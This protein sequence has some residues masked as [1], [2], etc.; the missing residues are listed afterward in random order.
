MWST[1]T[2]AVILKTRRKPK[3]LW[4]T[5]RRNST[6]TTELKRNTSPLK[7]TSFCLLPPPAAISGHSAIPKAYGTKVHHPSMQN[8][9][10]TTPLICSLT[11]T[12]SFSSKSS[13]ST[14]KLCSTETARNN[15]TE[16]TCSGSPGPSC[17]RLASQKPT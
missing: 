11:P 3:I 13:I 10:L 2:P 8:S 5:T 6:T 17:A 16:T 15:S 4:F 1:K 12:P 9:T 7:T 14:I